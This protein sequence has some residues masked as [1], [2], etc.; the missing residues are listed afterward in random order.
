MICATAVA[1][2]LLTGSPCTVR[3][4]GQQHRAPPDAERSTDRPKTRVGRRTVALPAVL[5]PEL[6]RHLAR[7]AEAASDGL[8]VRRG[9][10][11]L[12]GYAA[13]IAALAAAC[14][15]RLLAVRTLLEQLVY[16]IL[17]GHGDA[18]AKNF[19]VLQQPDGEWRVSP[20]AARHP[21][22]RRSNALP[23]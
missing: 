14:D 19:S 20:A 16:A 17:S 10:R 9:L 21:A 2:A 7:Y 5:L 12:V 23:R 8:V 15:V 13:S 18:H 4:G 11:D 22:V 6:E 3:G 1:D